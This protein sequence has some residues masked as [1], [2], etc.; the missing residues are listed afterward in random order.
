MDMSRRLAASVGFLA[1]SA[2]AGAHAGDRELGA[3]LS[4]EC[5]GC[6]QISGHVTGGVPRITGWPEDH[7]VAVMNSYKERL[8]ENPIM[9]TIA[10][11]LAD[12]EIAALAAYFGAATSQ[13]SAK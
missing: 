10:G 6:H 8:R 2:F 1:A 5:V 9:Q 11:R 12:D 4:N 7:F 13:S 3:Y